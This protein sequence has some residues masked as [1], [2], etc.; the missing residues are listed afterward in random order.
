V[1]IDKAHPVIVIYKLYFSN[2]RQ[3]W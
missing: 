3:P 2:N 1:I